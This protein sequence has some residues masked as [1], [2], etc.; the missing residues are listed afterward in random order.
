MFKLATVSV[1][2]NIN[3]HCKL[4]D[5]NERTREVDLIR[6]KDNILQSG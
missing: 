2:S 1:P 6:F 5:T 3:I 4:K